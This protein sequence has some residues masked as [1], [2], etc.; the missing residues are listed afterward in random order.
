MSTE[1]EIPERP[2][3]ELSA[4]RKRAPQA[5]AL[6]RNRKIRCSLIRTGIP[7]EQCIRMRSDCTTIPSRRSRQ[8]RLQNGQRHEVGANRPWL[9]PR[10]SQSPSAP[11]SSAADA[12]LHASPSLASTISLSGEIPAKSTLPPSSTVL[13][14]DHDTNH[15]NN[16]ELPAYI[17]PASRELD[18]GDLDFLR[19]CGALSIPHG[20]L[21]DQLLLAFV[22]YVYPQLPVVDLQ[23]ICD[24]IGVRTGCKISLL[25]FQAIMFSGTAF[26]DLQALIDAGFE[27]RLAAR[28]YFFRKIKASAYVR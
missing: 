18:A 23:D 1:S 26:V 5:C 6:C 17:R 28:A 16:A 25:L 3:S 19:S 27:N 14:R 4:P 15:D 9:L 22:L 7:C 13:Q 21:R 11:S 10:P 20:S 12:P 8:Y 2:S 24:A